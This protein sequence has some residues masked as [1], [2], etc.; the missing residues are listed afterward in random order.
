MTEVTDSPKLRLGPVGAFVAGREVVSFFVL[1]LA[2]SWAVWIPMAVGLVD[3]GSLV[4]GAIGVGTFGPLVAAA[5]V[6]WLVGDSLRAWA[7][8][9]LRWRV[10]PRW[11]LAAVGIPIVVSGVTIGVYAA[12]GNP[13]E[14][15]AILQRYELAL[16]LIYVLIIVVTFVVGGGQEELGWRGF[17]LPRLL[18][19]VDAVTASLVIG[20]VWAVWHLPLFLIEGSPQYGGPFIPYAITVV[21]L[22]MLF[23]WLYRATGRSVLLVMLLHASHNNGSVLIPFHPVQTGTVTMSWILAAVMGT[24]ALGLVVVYDRDLRSGDP[25]DH[26]TGEGRVPPAS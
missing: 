21:G 19:R 15:S 26:E 16:V 1:T 8:Q 2:L 10:H 5:I 18:D 13:I 25:D 7:G 23:T 6:T 17:A 20:A 14:L 24:L 4:L 9:V 22:S 12:L 11:Y 3:F